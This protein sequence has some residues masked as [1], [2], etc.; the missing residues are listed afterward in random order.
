MSFTVF[1]AWGYEV[2]ALEFIAAITS[3]TGVGLA[4]PVSASLGH[5]GR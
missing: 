1:T 5:G 2:S 3:F 4:Q